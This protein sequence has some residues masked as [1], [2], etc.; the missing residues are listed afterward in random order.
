MTVAA[1]F[2]LSIFGAQLVRL[3]G[4]DS[5]AV[6]AEALKQRLADETIPA[7]R[8][9]IRSSDGVVLASS[10]IRETVAVD[11]TVVC[12]YGTGSDTCD[13]ST[14]PSAVAAATVKLAPLLDTSP[15]ALQPLLTGTAKYRVLDRNV[16]E[17]TWNKI[18]ALHIPGVYRDRREARSERIYPQGATTASL[19]GFTLNDGTPGGGVEQMLDSTLKGTPGNAAY[20]AAADGTVIPAG[21]REITPARNGRDVTLTIN[22]NLQWYAQNALAAKVKQTAALSGT[23]VAMDAR[24]GKLLALASYP[25]FDPNNLAKATGSLANRAFNDVFEPGSTGKIMTVAAA[26]QEGNVTA[27]TPVVIP[28][29]L[30]R[31]DSWFHDAEPHGTEYRTVAGVLAESSNI[32]T[33]LIGEKM[34]PKTLE[35]YFRKF[36]LG[37]HLGHRLPG[38]GVRHPRSLAELERHPAL[39][40]GLRPG[41]VGDRDPGRRGLPDH[42]QRR[43]PGP[44]AAGRRHRELR[45]DL[46]GSPPGRRDPGRV[47]PGGLRPQPDARGRRQQPGHR[48]PGADPRLPGRRQ[49]RHRRPLRRGRQR[50][51]G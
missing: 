49:D 38:R 46:P 37:L 21:V 45:R 5:S 39:H 7:M 41:A 43:R 44:A 31:S 28:S 34:P 23:V 18:D 42:R 8:G 48:P 26:M 3:Q 2:V 4:L 6:A 32:G 9:V 47:H 27:S 51:R 12:T 50:Y 17:D 33:I 22:S 24:T 25:K 20:E 16:T 30:H 1:L 14:A 36:G 35:T 29:P 40:G 10:V 19:V 13:D 15:E 11:Q